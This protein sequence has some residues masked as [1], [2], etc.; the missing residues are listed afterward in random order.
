MNK[1]LVRT[2]RLTLDIDVDTDNAIVLAIRY[3]DDENVKNV[4]ENKKDK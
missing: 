3:V 4:F 1:K 2:I